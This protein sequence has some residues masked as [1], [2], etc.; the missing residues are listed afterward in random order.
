MIKYKCGPF[1]NIHSL[2]QTQ[3]NLKIY[4]TLLH[5]LRIIYLSKQYLWTKAKLHFYWMARWIKRY[6]IGGGNY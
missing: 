1:V 2:A 5:G 4:M 3:A 6:Q